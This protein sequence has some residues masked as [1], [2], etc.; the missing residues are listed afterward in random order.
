VTVT[1]RRC[2]ALYESVVLSIDTNGAG[3]AAT[4]FERALTTVWALRLCQLDYAA[5]GAPG[6]SRTL[7]PKDLV[8]SQARLPFAP[9]VQGVDMYRRRESNAVT[10][11]YKL[12]AV[13]PDG[14]R[15]EGFPLLQRRGSNSRPSPY[16][17]AALPPCSAAQMV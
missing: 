8:L 9:R 5:I 14:R 6:E 4:R 13:T 16:E 11:R 1:L 10:S 3:V 2:C 17:G 7:T 12:E 15:H